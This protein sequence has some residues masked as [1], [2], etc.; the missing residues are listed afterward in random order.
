MLKHRRQPDQ[1]CGSVAAFKI[2]QMEQGL[3]IDIA[4]VIINEQAAEVRGKTG[5][6]CV[7][8]HEQVGNLP[9][10]MIGWEWFLF[11]DIQHSRGE[12]SFL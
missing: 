10:G 7:E 1:R 8:G 5:G 6:G 11:E 12:S 4:M 2:N 3:V 9:E